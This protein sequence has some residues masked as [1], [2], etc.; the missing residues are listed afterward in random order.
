MEYR[1]R[2]ESKYLCSFCRDSENTASC[3]FKTAVKKRFHA[4]RDFSSSDE[5]TS[6]GECPDLEI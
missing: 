2:D 5:K 6:F 3:A 1:K 4:E